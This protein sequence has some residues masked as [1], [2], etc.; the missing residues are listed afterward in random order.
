MPMALTRSS[1]ERVELPSRALVDFARVE[2]TPAPQPPDPC[3]E[4][5]DLCV[6]RPR[7]AGLIEIVFQS[8]VTLRVDAGVDAAALDGGL[9]VLD[10]R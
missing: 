7:P 8:G 3:D 2:M 1:T 4:Q 5:H 9:A 6:T 10:Q